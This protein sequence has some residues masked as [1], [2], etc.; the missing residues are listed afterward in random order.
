MKI[1]IT[2]GKGN[3]AKIIK[4]NLP[5][6]YLIVSPGRD[7]LD[8]LNF[9][10]V[11]SFLTNNFFDVCFHTAIIGGRRTKEENYDVFYKNILMFENL[12]FF[13]DNFKMIINFDSGAIYDRNTDIFNRKEEEIN[14][15]PNDFYGFSKYCI[16]QRSLNIKNLFNFRIFNIFHPNEEQD[17][18]IKLCLNN[19]QI[20][21]SDDKYFDFFYY[22]DFI[23]I[24][25][26]Y[27]SKLNNM[28][29]LKKTINISYKKK[30]KLSEI[31]KLINPEII[32]MIEKKDSNN[33][34]TGESLK[35]ENFNI[36]FMDLD[37]VIIDYKMKIKNK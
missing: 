12:M 2:G 5:N 22:L 11:N 32:L 6:D 27:L 26:Y 10:K 35:I 36:E 30:Y 15:I 37:D 14:S 9:N 17:R 31:A 8:L 25:E 13:K 16:Y 29:E 20:T 34:Y 1:L 3:I 7:E 33:N 21:I 4:E 18:F 28:I 19:S 23:K 24:I